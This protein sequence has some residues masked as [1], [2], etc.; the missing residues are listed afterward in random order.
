MKTEKHSCLLKKKLARIKINGIKENFI[1]LKFLH[2]FYI[3]HQHFKS[4][5]C[6]IKSN[7]YDSLQN[8]CLRHGDPP[9][10]CN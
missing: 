10:F 9:K 8:Q 7:N 3:I 6:R 1:Y 4:K 5:I 2:I